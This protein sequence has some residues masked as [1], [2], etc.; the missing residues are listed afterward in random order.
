MTIGNPAIP[1]VAIKSLPK[2]ETLP[3]PL[4]SLRLSS[5]TIRRAACGVTSSVLAELPAEITGFAITDSTNSGSFEDVRGPSS[6]R[7]NIFCASDTHMLKRG[8]RGPGF[9]GDDCL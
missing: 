5:K 9:E 2:P 3:L 4:I 6:F 8:Q 1:K 7:S